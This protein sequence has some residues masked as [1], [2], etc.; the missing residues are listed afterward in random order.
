[1]G[2][3]RNFHNCQT[4]EVEWREKQ[5]KNEWKKEKKRRKKRRK[6]RKREEKMEATKYTRLPVALLQPISIHWQYVWCR[7]E[8]L[9]HCHSKYLAHFTLYCLRS[10]WISVIILN[11]APEH[12][13]I[14]NV[15]IWN[16][17]LNM[18][19]CVWC[20]DSFKTA[21]CCFALTTS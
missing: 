10:K 4:V 2:S 19:Y 18:A 14:S 17:H 13:C 8:P 7:L 16:L 12:R 9:F 6:K 1:M 3:L 15:N 11:I 5:G 20:T 21:S